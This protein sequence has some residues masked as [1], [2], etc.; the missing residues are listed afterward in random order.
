[1]IV[2]LEAGFLRGGIR[3]QKLVLFRDITFDCKSFC[4]FVPKRLYTSL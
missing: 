4:G 3:Y 2:K 1:L